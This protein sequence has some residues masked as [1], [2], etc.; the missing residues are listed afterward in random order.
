MEKYEKLLGK[1]RELFQLQTGMGIVRWDLQTY[2]PPKG[3]KQRSEQLALLSKLWHRMATDKEL[4]QLVKDLQ[5]EKESLN[6]EQIR[7]IDLVNRRLNRILGIPEDLVA[8]ESAQRT[9]TTAT[10]KKAKDTNNWK[11]F[12]SELVTLF[13]ITRKM[14]EMTME[15]VGVECPFDSLIDYYEPRM[16][17]KN[18]ARVFSDLRS[19]LIPRVKKY[20]TLCEEVDI[21]FKKREVPVAIQRRLLTDLAAVIGYDTTSENAGGR[22]DESEHP[23]TTGYYDDVRLTVRFDTRDIL[24]GV[25]GGL[26]E[27]GHAIHNQNQNPKWKWMM[28][29][30]SCSSGFGE[31]QSRFIENIIGKSQELWKFYFPQFQRL[32]DGIFKDV[33]YEEFLRGINHVRA[34]SLRILADEMTYALHIIV[35]FEI[36]QDMFDDRVEF[37]E[38]PQVWNE[39]FEEYLGIEVTSDTEGALQDVHWAWGMWGYFPNYALGNLYAAMIR[40]K[41]CHDIPEWLNEVAEGNLETPIQWLI[42]NVHRK[43]NLYDPADMIMKITGKSLTVEPFISYLDE[44]YSA[45]YG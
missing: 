24:R 15:D 10:W 37:S 44:K 26:H 42:Q 17:S 30:W 34:S 29:G 22:I 13:D 45:L 23:F 7:E 31:S 38:I 36:E 8:Q 19:K 27:T 21:E 12:E 40:E 11:L 16:T 25:F 1:T 39:K 5:K 43:S 3:M 6:Q 28:L 20:S 35:R 33:S 18:I 41:M 14:A 32:T 4:E 2:M 9:V